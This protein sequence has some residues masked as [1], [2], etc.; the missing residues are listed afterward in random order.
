MVV[1]VI[2]IGPPGNKDSRHAIKSFAHKAA[3]FLRVG[4]HPLIVDMFPPRHATRSAA[5]P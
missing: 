1:A 5:A 4:V 3:V 2:E